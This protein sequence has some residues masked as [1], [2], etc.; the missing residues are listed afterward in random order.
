MTV[1]I[2]GYKWTVLFVN[3]DHEG[4]QL[5]DQEM[6]ALGNTFFV[7]LKIYIR[8]NENFELVRKTVIHELVHAV[9]FSYGYEVLGEESICQFYA[10]QSDRIM[11]LTNKIM[12]GWD[13]C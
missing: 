4:L 9:I 8:K 5:K 12:K 11:K 7:D 10:E 13:K 6:I 1:K 2:N 3:G